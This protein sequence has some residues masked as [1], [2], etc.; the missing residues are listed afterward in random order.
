[1]RMMLALMALLLATSLQAGG[2]YRWVDPDG[3]VIYGDEPP[4]TVAPNLVEIPPAP[5]AT[6]DASPNPVAPAAGAQSSFREGKE[7]VVA[8][9]R[10]RL[11]DQSCAGLLLNLKN[12]RR[13]DAVYRDETGHYQYQR[14]EFS[15][16]YEGQRYY[17]GDRERESVITEMD[18]RFRSECRQGGESIAQYERLIARQQR[19]QYCDDLKSAMVSLEQGSAL[20]PGSDQRTLEDRYRNS[21]GPGSRL[22]RF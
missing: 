22:Q 12:L 9:T 1:M 15:K 18:L 10:E 20:K 13:E 16:G 5:A 6:V 17:L 7:P 4:E 21:C 8:R 2:I 14:S 19:R 3:K 11:T